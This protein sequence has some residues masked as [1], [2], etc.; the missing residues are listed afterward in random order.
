MTKLDKTNNAV[1]SLN[2]HLI[3]VVKYRQKV[4]KDD[5]MIND[6]KT[7]ITDISKDFDVEVIEQQCR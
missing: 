3:S 7:I 1:F 5:T 4:F 6:L 2:Y